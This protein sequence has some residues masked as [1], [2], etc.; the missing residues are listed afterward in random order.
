MAG[1]ATYLNFPGTTEEAFEF[2][3]SVFGGDYLSP[4]MRFGDVPDQD[5]APPM[6][7]GDRQKIMHVSL[8]ILGGHLLM[9][10]DAVESMGQS[11]TAG[12]NVHIMLNP[13]TRA[14]ADELFA[15]LSEGGA[16]LVPM[17]DMFWGD[18]YGSCRD[19]FG[20]R[21]MIDL[22]SDAPAE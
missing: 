3:R 20:T 4:P 12:D 15:K 10:T 2:Y 19:R 18:Y 6:S 5:D 22:P 21:W 8:P 13:D 7:D 14:E 16:D 17:H 1:V 11:V 9:G